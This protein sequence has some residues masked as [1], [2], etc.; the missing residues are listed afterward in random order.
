MARLGDA[1][2]VVLGNAQQEK[3]TTQPGGS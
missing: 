2:E 3:H 1:A